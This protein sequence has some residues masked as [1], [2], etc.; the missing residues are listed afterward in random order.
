MSDDA[1]RRRIAGLKEEYP[2][3]KSEETPLDE[4]EHWTDEE[5]RLYAYSNGYIKP[6]T[7]KVAT[8]AVA[9]AAAAAAAATSSS[10]SRALS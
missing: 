8:T 6:R 10:T 3:W 1:V 7:K 4:A 5:L 2:G 9:A